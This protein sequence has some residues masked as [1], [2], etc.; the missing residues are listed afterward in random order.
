[1]RRNQTSIRLYAAGVLLGALAFTALPVAAQQFG[2]TGPSRTIN[3]TP[4]FTRSAATP[5]LVY[6]PN[7]PDGTSEFSVCQAAPDGSVAGCVAPELAVYNDMLYMSGRYLRANAALTIGNSNSGAI[8]ITPVTANIVLNAP[9]TYE[10]NIPA[11]ATLNLSACTY[12]STAK[13]CFL[14]PQSPGA[15][16]IPTTLEG[17][18]GYRADTNQAFLLGGT[19]G[20]LTTRYILD[21]AHVVTVAQGGTGLTAGTS[22]GL[23]TYTDTGTL[24]S[25]GLLTQYGVV[26]GGGAGA[27]VTSTANGTTGQVLTAN[28]GAAPTWQAAAGGGLMSEA[29]TR[30]VSFALPTSTAA[31]TFTAYG[32]ASLTASA[33]NTAVQDGEGLWVRYTTANAAANEERGITG[34]YTQGE[35]RGGP[36]STI[37]FRTDAGSIANRR[38]IVGLTSGEFIELISP[39]AG[40]A[41]L[42]AAIDG[43]FVIYDSAV[44]GN[45]WCCAGDGGTNLG[46]CTDMALA[47]ATNTTYVVTVNASNAT[48]YTCT[49]NATTATRTTNLPD[50]A[51]SRD[52][53]MQ[54]DIYTLAQQAA[55]FDVGRLYISLE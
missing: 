48:S 46:G 41:S 13:Q 28:T 43:L 39:V 38:Y 42:G 24:A 32:I 53:G 34:G 35:F 40:P 10:T 29:L 18:F 36:I 52:I 30:R 55:I 6:A 45:W 4:G 25:S 9:A 21:D 15:P 14:P 5:L 47:V 26:L 19:A 31:S 23:P 16:S 1:M 27:V 51:S 7:V 3:T 8:T 12:S 49:V 44:N 22:G 11:L 17:Y 37:K 50:P 2:V 20:A 54:A 33:G